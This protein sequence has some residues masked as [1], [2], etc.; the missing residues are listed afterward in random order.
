M[1]F[2]H[3]APFE[4]MLHSDKIRA[5]L[6]SLRAF[7]ILAILG[8][9]IGCIEK[10]TRPDLE[11]AETEINTLLDA[12]HEAAATADEEV[13][14]GTMHPRAIYL[15]TDKTERWTRDELQ[16]WAG[17]YFERDTAWAF[18]PLERHLNYSRDG[19]TAW[20]DE[21]LDTWMGVCRGSGV[22]TRE[23]QGWTLRHYNLSMTIDNDVVDGVIR[24]HQEP[25]PMSVDSLVSTDQ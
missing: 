11:R 14:F 19:K 7:L 10:E 13:F 2:D 16:A 23:Q 22:L 17:K 4:W 1:S 3:T 6:T 25:A 9:T 15:G 20:F 18:T 24:L 12:W 21:Q 8:S 5:M